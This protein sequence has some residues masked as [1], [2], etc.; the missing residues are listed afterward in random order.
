MPYLFD[1]FHF[2]HLH[3]LHDFFKKIAFLKANKRNSV[4]TTGTSSPGTTS[5]ALQQV[6]QFLEQASQTSAKSPQAKI[7]NFPQSAVFS[8][9]WSLGD[10]LF[11]IS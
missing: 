3:V 10:N 1:I 8:F 9:I 2:F 6:S 7:V 11:Y 5:E 4:L